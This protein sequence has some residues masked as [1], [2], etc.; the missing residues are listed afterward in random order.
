MNVT[1]HFVT[2]GNRRVHYHR[3]GEGP[4]V[5]LL[6]ASPCSAKVLRQPLEAFAMRFPVFMSRPGK[7]TLRVTAR[8]KVANKSSTYELPVTVLS[9]N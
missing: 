6:H 9:P 1:K 4:A 5:A 3:A 7:Y 8:D 2:V